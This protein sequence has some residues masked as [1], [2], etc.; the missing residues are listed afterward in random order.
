MAHRIAH[1][2][3]V[4]MEQQRD[5]LR[6]GRAHRLLSILVFDLLDG[7]C[8]VPA[9][10]DSNAGGGGGDGGGGIQVPRGRTRL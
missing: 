4:V 6:T 3:V 8:H 10:G 1:M 9:A 7:G 2:E 5:Q